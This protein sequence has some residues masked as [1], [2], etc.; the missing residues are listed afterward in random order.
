MANHLAQHDYSLTLNELAELINE[1]MD[2]LKNKHQA[3]EWRD[4]VVEP[5]DNDR[6]KLR[7]RKEHRRKSKIVKDD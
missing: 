5:V 2:Y 1:P 6:W 4:W 3:W 7:F